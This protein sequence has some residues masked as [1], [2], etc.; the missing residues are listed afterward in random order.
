MNFEDF[1]QILKSA[2][3]LH[4]DGQLRA[5]HVILG[6]KPS[7]RC[8][9]SLK[10]VIKTKDPRLALIDVVFPGF[11]TEPPPLGPQDAVLFAQLAAKLLYS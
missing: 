3:F 7:S 10:Q 11:L 2:I 9:Q 6:F 8:F 4:R 1:N 5:V